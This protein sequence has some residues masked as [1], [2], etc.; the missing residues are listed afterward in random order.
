MKINASTSLLWVVL[1]AYLLV[2]YYFIGNK[3]SNLICKGVKIEFENKDGKN[4]VNKKDITKLVFNNFNLVG[5]KIETVD[6]NKLEKLINNNTSIKNVE[7]YSSITGNVCILL[8]QK[9]PI[10]RI[11]DGGNGYYVDSDGEL[12][13]WSSNYTARTLVASGFINKKKA[14][15]DLLNLANFIYKSKFWKSQISQIYVRKNE[16]YILIPKVGGHKIEFG[17]IDNFNTKFDK[18]YAL[19]KDGF[20]KSGWNKYKTINLKYENQIVC[21]KR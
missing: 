4:F 21:T 17:T 8:K 19:Y 18:L 10:I 13:S 3:G 6:K 16:E 14:K 20:T 1:F 12:M 5:E 15:G 7:V 9:K 2:V 11:L